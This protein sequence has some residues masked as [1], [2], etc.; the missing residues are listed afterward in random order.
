[1]LWCLSLS[2]GQAQIVSNP[3]FH[4]LLPASPFNTCTTADVQQ[5]DLDG[6]CYAWISP[7]N[8]SP[9]FFYGCDN[10]G[11]PDHGVPINMRFNGPLDDPFYPSTSS[12]LETQAYAGIAISETPGN[13]AYREYITQELAEPLEPGIYNISFLV[14]S[15]NMPNNYLIKQLGCL[16]TTADPNLSNTYAINTTIGDYVAIN[17]ATGF[18]SSQWYTVTAQINVTGATKTYLTIGNFQPNIADVDWIA[19]PGDGPVAVDD[20]FAYYFIDNVYIC[21]PCAVE[22]EITKVASDDPTK[23]C[24]D[25]SILSENRSCNVFSGFRIRSATTG[26]TLYTKN[27]PYGWASEDFS[28]CF[29]RFESQVVLIELLDGNGQVACVKS[30]ELTCNC[31]C[32]NFLNQPGLSI[33]VTPAAGGGGGSCCWEVRVENNTNIYN[34]GCDLLVKGIAFTIARPPATM[35]YAPGYG[36]STVGG[37]T[38]IAKNPAGDIYKV[39]TSTLIATICLPQ[40]TLDFPVKFDVLQGFLPGNQPIKCGSGYSTT[41][42]C[43]NQCCAEVL[44]AVKVPAFSG[45]PL[46]CCFNINVQMMNNFSCIRS[47]VVQVYNGTA[48]VNESLMNLI[49]PANLSFTIPQ[50]ITVG[51]SKKIRLVFRNAAGGL[52]TA[53][54]IKEFTLGC[55]ADCCSAVT[56]LQANRMFLES[57]CYRVHGY[58]D[59]TSQCPLDNYVIEQNVPGTSIWNPIGSGIPGADDYFESVVCIS[60]T[61]ATIRIQFRNAAGTVICTRWISLNCVPIPPP[62]KMGAENMNN[63]LQP[64]VYAVPNPAVGETTIHYTLRETSD[65]RLS[66]YNMLGEMMIELQSSQMSAG[67][68]AT[69][70]QTND[71][72]SGMYFMQVH[73][74]NG[75]VTIPITIVK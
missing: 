44:S 25:L 35:G 6:D 31:R 53:V 21:E 5:N 3:Y 36:A 60:G 32:D 67:A 55:E 40:G 64:E 39:G 14:R 51:T 34:D 12:T 63:N 68:Q 17:H 18:P 11:G 16:F 69:T 56:D 41:L 73:A 75:V 57:C 22:V 49:P 43:A 27:T 26:Q 2:S 29:D 52:G 37:T 72:P 46:K 61:S 58:M 33:S 62:G 13:P 8:A 66:L 74:G 19:Q 71:L 38:Y 15:S 28:I 1:M 23:C 9:D 45:D 4:S 20:G 65:V 47:V 7:N 50:C 42:S 10:T 70:I 54:C 59:S 24:Y 30:R 48:W